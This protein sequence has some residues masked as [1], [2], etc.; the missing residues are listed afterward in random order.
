MSGEERVPRGTDVKRNTGVI[1]AAI[2]VVGAVVVL[3]SSMAL[4]NRAGDAAP[5]P[6]PDS[7]RLPPL[8]PSNRPVFRRSWRIPQAALPARWM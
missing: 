8:D 2:A 5:M 3:G 6:T 4:L 1:V 7:P